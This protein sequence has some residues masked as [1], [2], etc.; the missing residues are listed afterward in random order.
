MI[1]LIKE[2]KIKNFKSFDGVFSLK[3]N[4]GVNVIV[5]DNEAG[6]STII[7]AI[8]L[9]LSGFM[10][11][12]FI[13]NDLSQYLFNNAVVARYIKDLTEKKTAE[14]PEI[15][16]ELHFDGENTA[17]FLG[18]DNIDNQNDCGVF[19]KIAFDE[20]YQQEYE[21]L[22]KAGDVRTLPLEY[23][24]VFWSSFA[25]EAITARMI[26]IKSAL[27]DAGGSRYQNG[28]DVYI[29]RI[30]KDFLESEDVVAIAQAHR[31]MRD[32]FGE[33]VSVKNINDRIK[34]ATN[35]SDKEVKLDV[36]LSSKNAWET[37][38]L[39][40][41]DDVPFHFIGKGEQSI[42]KTKLALSHKKAKEANVILFEEPENHLSHTKLNQLIKD[43]VSHQGKKQIIVSTHSN[44]I[45]N[46]LGLANLILLNDHKT[47]KLNDLEGDT[48][49]FF[50]KLPG[51]DTLRLILCKKAILV[52][53]SSD[54]LI[55]Q[56][57]YMDKNSGRLPIEDG[58]DVIS[59]GTSFLR[60]L[61]IA[62]ALHKE[63]VVLTD[64][65]GSTTAL[66]KKY[67]DYLGDNKKEYITICYDG[68]IDVGSLKIGE[69]PY[70]YNTLE[71]KM[72]KANSLGL[73]NKIFSTS[74]KS[75]DELRRYMQANK[76]ECAL[77]L[78]DTKEP[79]DYPQYILDAIG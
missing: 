25:R 13:K 26:P 29:S 79:L 45:A 30:V 40:Y 15:I 69:N 10:G 72:L 44:F 21:E 7:E 43:I 75:A 16:I 3:L 65:D 64:N 31:K 52:E 74:Y 33:D 51:Y 24:D 17:R 42:V 57:A 70:N 49:D 55:V 18:N 36:D 22:V 67:A 4:G 12:K 71:P 5:G 73:F 59:V 27:I 62:N 46:K 6:K 54:E 50:S 77:A 63:V 19:M 76:T 53:G 8:N 78:F 61:E 2:I 38:L 9:A 37:S 14:M 56:R 1:P 66:E 23:Y 41:L 68:Q 34:T 48:Q 60:F 47:L 39:T 20:K 58:I 28:S 32:A 35:I 11:G